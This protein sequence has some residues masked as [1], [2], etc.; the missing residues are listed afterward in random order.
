MKKFYEGER[1][2]VKDYLDYLETDE[3][4]KR[5]SIAI[6]QLKNAKLKIQRVHDLSRDL[7]EHI[8]NI[9]E[10]IS[11]LESKR[12]ME[13]YSLSHINSK[14]ILVNSLSTLKKELEYLETRKKDLLKKEEDLLKMGEELIKENKTDLDKL[15]RR[16][17]KKLIKLKVSKRE[18]VVAQ[19]RLIDAQLE[20]FLKEKN[21]FEELND[22]GKKRLFN[23]NKE[24]NN[25]KDLK[26]KLTKKL[27][28]ADGD[29]VE[30]TKQLKK[31]KLER[32]LLQRKFNK[33]ISTY[34]GVQ[35]KKIKKEIDKYVQE[36]N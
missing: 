35:S 17:L 23:L 30:I 32:D 11:E 24:I 5:T 25:L 10:K 28:L 2:N 9:E 18:N 31:L 16:E 4:K 36:I 15:Q 14:S 27:Q 34:G 1:R 8:K 26:I 3:L 7:K 29:A 22:V 6:V 19:R 33:T 21:I 20:M 12:K 13:E